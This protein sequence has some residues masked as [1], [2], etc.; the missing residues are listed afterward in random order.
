MSKIKKIVAIG[1]GVGVIVAGGLLT[2]CTSTKDTTIQ[3]QQT[4][5]A[6]LQTKLTEAQQ[7]ASFA[8]TE[9]QAKETLSAELESAK[10]Q[11]D[12]KDKALLAYEVSTAAQEDLVESEVADD[13]ELG[14]AVPET[15]VNY[16]DVE[17][18]QKGKVY[19]NGEDFDFEETVSF[20]DLKVATSLADD[21]ELSETPTLYFTEE[22]G[23][24][25]K[26][27]F[28]DQLDYSE[29][30]TDEP[31]VLNFLGKPLTVVEVTEDSLTYREAEQY[32]VKEG[33]SVVVNGKTVTVSVITSNKVF[34]TVDGVGK[35]IYE[36]QSRLIG[37]LD[38]GVKETFYKDYAGANNFVELL[39]GKDVERTV[40]DGDEYVDE[41]ETY[42]WS[43][44]TDGD[45][46][47]SIGVRYDVKADNYDEEVLKP[48]QKL[49]FADYFS[50][51]FDLEEEYVYQDA[52][53]SFTTV[54]EDDVKVVK[55]ET[56]EDGL[57]AG[58]KRLAKAYLDVDN[59]VWFKEDGDWLSLEEDL[60]VVNDD[61]K[62]QVKYDG[63]AVTV[64]D[65]IALTT[66]LEY[67]G[68]EKKEAEETDVVV[69]GKDLGNREESVLLS[70]GVV[71]HSVEA[72]A[73][74][75]TVK[76]SLPNKVVKAVLHLLK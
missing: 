45:Y 59:T 30:S 20:S 66:N 44:Q 74:K 35:T 52:T 70:N 17:S 21:A 26:Y 67:L 53:L 75:D 38:V 36:G 69:D 22:G 13:L 16:Y 2:G 57:K 32:D 12:E 37:D 34:V 6:D 10:L 72:N 31:L 14:S 5:L 11:L 43:L 68:A 54:T 76:L 47:A 9:K 40:S 7:Q 46:L 27:E 64:G 42:V 61:V 4:Q 58:S 56:S 28:K 3:Q 33:E 48:G 63:T 29:V 23:V 15:S 18:L 55:V 65:S 8:V 73:D 60:Y 49:N 51:Q 25:Y 71:V 24:A 1:L 50:V 39:V 19:F 41:D 62:L